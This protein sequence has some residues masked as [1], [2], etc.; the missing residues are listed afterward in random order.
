[1]G[2]WAEALGTTYLTKTPAEDAIRAESSAINPRTVEAL[3]R[4]W[5]FVAR[6]ASNRHGRLHCCSGYQ[7][8]RDPSPWGTE[9]GEKDSS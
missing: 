4:I 9:A 5:G 1:M 7:Q 3:T 2:S 6:V 8:Q